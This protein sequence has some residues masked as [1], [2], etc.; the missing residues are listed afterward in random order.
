VFTAAGVIHKIS[1]GLISVLGITSIDSELFALLGRG[2]NE[3][4]VYSINDY[5]LLRHISLPGYKTYS[6][7]YMA[8]CVLRKCLYM[9]QYLERHVLRLEL[10]SRSV[11]TWPVHGEPYGLSVMQNG[12]LLVTARNPN[13]LI[14]LSA[15]RGRRV[16]EISLQND[17]ENPWHSVQLANGQFVVCHG[18][19]RSLSRVCMIDDDGRVTRS[20]GGEEGSGDG[21]LHWPEHLAVDEDSQLIFVAD[22]CNHRVVV[23]SPKLE[24]VRYIIEIS[25][26]PARLYFDQTTRR[27]YVAHSRAGVTV[28]QF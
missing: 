2:G 17:I 28:I 18:A 16:R 24:F 3:V 11:S 20:Y 12:N 21:Q 5:K 23:L 15:E 1:A 14:E 22:S 19:Y 25:S 4:A 8:S 9:S 6:Q 10:A 27:L 26:E 7:N 13:V